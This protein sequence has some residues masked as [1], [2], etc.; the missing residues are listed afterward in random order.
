[1]QDLQLF[2]RT[3]TLCYMIMVELTCV[4]TAMASLLTDYKEEKLTFRAWLPFDYYASKT[5]FH[6]TYFHQLISLTIGSV[7][8]VA[9]DG[10][11]CGLLLHI[12]CQIEILS[13]RLKKIICNPRTNNYVNVM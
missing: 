3:N 10:L 9:C 11:I 12:C 2:Y 4:S 1:M 5:I 6:L 8:H 7:L 13:Y